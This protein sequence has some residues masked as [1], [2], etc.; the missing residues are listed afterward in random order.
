[1]AQSLLRAGRPMK[2]PPGIG[3]ELAS[4]YRARREAEAEEAAWQ[5]LKA[6]RYWHLS[7]LNA[8]ERDLVLRRTHGSDRPKAWW[9]NRLGG[10][11]GGDGPRLGN[12]A[13]R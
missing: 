11:D 3:S 5:A 6:K 13:P 7:Q 12:G 2:R 4:I 8:A 9:Q 10:E 1:L